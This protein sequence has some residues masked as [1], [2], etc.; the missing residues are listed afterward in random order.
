VTVASLDL[1]LIKARQ[2]DSVRTYPFWRRP[3][4]YGLLVDEEIEK[5]RRG[6]TH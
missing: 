6:S 5:R 2:E 4:T 3:S 1:D